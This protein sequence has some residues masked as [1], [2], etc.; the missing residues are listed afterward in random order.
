MGKTTTR[1]DNGTLR[2][3]GYDPGKLSA[4]ERKQA[5]EIERRLSQY[6]RVPAA[7]RRRPRALADLRTFIAAHPDAYQRP[8]PWPRKSKMEERAEQRAKPWDYGH[9][10]AGGEV[11]AQMDYYQEQFSRHL[12]GIGN[13]GAKIADLIAANKRRKF[14]FTPEFT[15]SLRGATILIK[16]LN[17]RM[18]GP[19]P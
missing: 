10:R 4:A 13:Y 2:L 9:V 3:L 12:R 16:K 11:V 18:G 7:R 14:R 15:H 1:Q 17:E 5:L 8:T 19:L 6:D